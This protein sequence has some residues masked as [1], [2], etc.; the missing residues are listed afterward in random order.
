MHGFT[1]DSMYLLSTLDNERVRRFTFGTI[2][3][4]K[5]IDWNTRVE[6][7]MMIT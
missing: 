2:I 6:V 1:E 3:W 7:M 5:S 4:L